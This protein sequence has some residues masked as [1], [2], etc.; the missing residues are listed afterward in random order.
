MKN[1]FVKIF[2]VDPSTNEEF[3]VNEFITVEIVQLLS[4]NPA[5]GINPKTLKF[6]KT[7][8]SFKTGFNR[9]PFDNNFYFRIGFKKPVFSKILKRLIGVEE[10][11]QSILP[12]YV[13]ARIPYWD[14]GWDDDYESNE[15]FGSDRLKFESSKDNPLTIKIPVREFFII[16]H[17]GA[18]YHFPENS[19]ASFKKALDIG[20]NGIELDICITK[21]D[22]LIVFHDAIPT[23][24]PSQFD[25]TI[26]EDLPYELKSPEFSNDGKYALIKEFAEGSWAI[27][28]KIK[29]KSEKNFDISNLTETQVKDF[30]KYELVNGEFHGIINFNDFLSF[31]SIERDR[32]RIL[33]LDVKL[34]RWNIHTDKDR[35]RKYG[36]LLCSYIKRFSN[37]PEHIVVSTPDKDFLQILKNAF[38]AGNEKRCSFA[39]D[40]EG[41][42]AAI[43]GI[44]ENPVKIARQM[45]NEV[46]SIGSLAR[47]G[48][49]DE[50]KEAVRDR[51]YN[52]KSNIKNVIHWTLNEKAQ[53]SYSIIAGV[54]G[55]LTDKPDELKSVLEKSFK[56]KVS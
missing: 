17:R 33:F 56:V 55:I 39:F 32:L 41:S 22:K 13:P 3:E 23:K 25:R 16:G 12:V 28:R 54:N 27:V 40:A 46:V 1:I 42:F 15:Y 31:A 34:P 5:V 9:Y 37:L 2:L 38:N 29:M 24:H 48:N 26:F 10:V 18:P 11:N 53:M 6:D 36:D 51:D 7:A 43:F 49:L 44:R 50:I 20:A 4:Y 52:H 21:D 19:L 35:F 45:E 14:T 30:Y 47:P 8:G